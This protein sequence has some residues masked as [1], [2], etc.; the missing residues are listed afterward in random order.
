ML[1]SVVL[2]EVSGIVLGIVLDNELSL[3]ALPDGIEVM[4]SPELQPVIST[5]ESARMAARM[6][7]TVFF[8][9]ICSFC[10]YFSGNTPVARSFG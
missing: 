8:M 2:M 6:I 7:E 5:N 1:S 9:L 10:R 3:V 4:S